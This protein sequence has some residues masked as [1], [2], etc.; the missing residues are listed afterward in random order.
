MGIAYLALAGTLLSSCTGGGE[1]SNSN[2]AFLMLALLQGTE[3]KSASDSFFCG[4]TRANA[5]SLTDNAA[6][7]AVSP[8]NSQGVLFSFFGSAI[9]KKMMAIFDLPVG[10]NGQLRFCNSSG[11]TLQTVN[12]N[13]TRM[14]EVLYA[15]FTTADTYYMFADGIG[16]TTGSFKAIVRSSFVTAVNKCEF[17][18]GCLSYG[19]D[20]V[21]ASAACTAEGGTYSAS[22][23]S[24]SNVQGRCTIIRAMNSGADS[25]PASFIG[26]TSGYTTNYASDAALETQC[27][28]LF[29]N[30]A[31]L[32]TS[33]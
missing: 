33:F 12:S 29:G 19:S 24:A 32:Y 23:C 18:F 9:T 17:N 13:G 27:N 11:T 6:A 1:G 26:Y 22:A 16:G 25:G 5:V 10:M 30:G 15:T 28:S 2:N 7:T 21:N 20:Y 3:K 8:T 14:P 31:Y 4:G